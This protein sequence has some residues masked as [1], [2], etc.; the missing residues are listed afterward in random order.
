M[1]LGFRHG[2]FQAQQKPVVEQAGMIQ[3]IHVTDESVRHPAQFQEP[4]PLSVIAREARGLQTK[5]DTDMAHGD[6]IGHLDKAVASD[7]AR[8]TVSQIFI[9]DFDLGF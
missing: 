3:P 2:P 9:D 8:T 4:I 1:Q 6:F 5:D 7:D